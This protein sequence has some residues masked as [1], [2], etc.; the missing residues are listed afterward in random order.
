MGEQDTKNRNS[1][2]SDRAI[3]TYCGGFLGFFFTALLA[4]LVGDLST[5]NSLVLILG[6]ISV[7]LIVGYLFPLVTETL[8][9]I[10]QLFF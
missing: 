3:A 10:A 4:M 7:G 9:W 2:C 8:F 6:G 1:R 5:T